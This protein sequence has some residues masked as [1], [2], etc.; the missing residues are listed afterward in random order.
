MV[1]YSSIPFVGAV[2][3]PKGYLDLNFPRLVTNRDTAEH[4]LYCLCCPCV[5]A[6]PPH[7]LVGSAEASLGN[8]TKRFNM[9]R[10]FWSLLKTLGLWNCEVYL[11]RKS[12]RTSRDD[13]REIIPQCI[14][15]VQ[16]TESTIEF[17]HTYTL[18]LCVRVRG[19]YCTQ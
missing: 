11:M 12:A 7:F 16:F 3:P 8:T 2:R 9:Y 17:I 15:Q 13:P 1:L 19:S 4:C 14:V 10:K 6:L 18:Y 5:I